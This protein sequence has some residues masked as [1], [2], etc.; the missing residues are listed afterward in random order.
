MDQLVQEGKLKQMLHH[1]S[2]LGRQTN[3][4]FER[5]A[6]L[7]PPLGTI[8]VIFA[9]P[10]RTGLCPFKVMSVARLSFEGTNH[11]SK[12]VRVERPLVM[13]FSNEDKVVTI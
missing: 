7:R 8:N 5:E 9:A 13:G 2:N 1:F 3:S 12:R 6:P 11:E 10:G 4:Q